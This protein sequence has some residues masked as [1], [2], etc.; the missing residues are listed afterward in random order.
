MQA[1]GRGKSGEA[2]PCELA[3]LGGPRGELCRVQGRSGKRKCCKTKEIVISARPAARPV[4][5]VRVGIVGAGGIA[6]LHA[7][8]YKEFPDVELVAVCDIVEERAR[9]FAQRWGIP[10]EN[11]FTDYV[12][13]FES[14]KMDAVS[15]CTP[16]AVHAQPAVE[17]LR[18]GIHVHVEK[19]MASR[20][21]DAL[22]MWR[23]AKEAGKILMVGF[24]TR[25][26]PELVAARRI[27]AS[28]ALGRIY[29][30]ETTLGG[31]RRGI[32]GS[33]TFI[34]RELAGGGVVLDLGCYAIDN[35]LYV[36]G[37]PRPLTVSASIEAAIGPQEGAV[38]EGGWAWN[39][40]EFEVE[41]FV[42]ALVRLEGGCTLLLKESWAMHANSLGPSLILGTKGGLKYP[43][44]EVYRD[45]WG[46]MTTTTLVLPQ[47][48]SFRMKMRAF[49]DAVKRGGPSPVDP[50]EIVIEQYIL[51][52]I[53]E[54]ARRG[55]EVEVRLP[56]ELLE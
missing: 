25:W 17:A 44:L 39:P 37:F 7:R 36:L 46:Y 21:E 4:E 43:P 40:R 42:V 8:Y 45:E 13:M 51:D 56:P 2:V 52:A 19:P 16:H 23:A 12:E 26:S 15:I 31:R 30:C 29:Y 14:V 38:V 32:P 48:D 10:R 11:V 22:R 41:D 20:G 35:A 18:R 33:P 28:G 27:V 6:N 34:K 5:K 49:V 53:Y 47:V 54:S 9:D 50:K 24:Q 1:R 3:T 55:R